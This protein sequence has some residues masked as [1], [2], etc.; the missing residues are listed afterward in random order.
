MEKLVSVLGKA[1]SELSYE[2]LIQLAEREARRMDFV[3]RA[4]APKSKTKKKKATSTPKPKSSTKV[5]KNKL[6][7]IARLTG[8]PL[9]D[10]L[11]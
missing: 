10:L 8:V 5:S 6:A 9:E 7:E 2:D 3:L 11:K 1:P 4:S